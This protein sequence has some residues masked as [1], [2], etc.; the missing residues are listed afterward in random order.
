MINEVQNLEGKAIYIFLGGKSSYKAKKECDG[1]KIC[2]LF[3][4]K[5]GKAKHKYETRRG[6]IRPE[7]VTHAKNSSNISI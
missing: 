1:N 6:C 3:H 5:G 4:E 2:C 7:F